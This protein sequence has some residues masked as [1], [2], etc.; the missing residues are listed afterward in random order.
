MAKFRCAL[1]SNLRQSIGAVVSACEANCDPQGFLLALSAFS[2]AETARSRTWSSVQE[3][4]GDAVC[5]PLGASGE[6][7]RYVRFG[8]MLD[9][10]LLRAQVVGRFSSSKLDLTFHWRIHCDEMG[11]VQHRARLVP[12]VVDSTLSK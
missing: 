4:F 3:K 2:S 5:F 1:P 12:N 6:L 8:G 11:R 7:L 10:V 9:I